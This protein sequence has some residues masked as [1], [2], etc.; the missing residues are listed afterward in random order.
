M[1]DDIMVSAVCMTYN[2]EEFIRDAIEGILNQKTDF[3]FELIIHDDAS[4]DGT[5]KIV[6]EY[7][8]KYPEII[9]PILQSTNQKQKGRNIWLSFILPEVRG[10]YIAICEGD[11]YWI[12]EDKLQIQTDFMENHQDYSMCMHNAVKLN[13]GTGEKVRMDT[14]EEAG[15]Y[16]Q[17]EHLQIGLGSDFPAFASYFLRANDWKDMPEIFW[18]GV[19]LDYSLRQ[20]YASKG[21]IYYFKEPMSVYR[22]HVPGSY[23]KRIAASQSKYN[24]YVLRMIRFYE[25]LD[26]Y[27]D[28]KFHHILMRKIVSD[29]MGFCLSIDREEGMQKAAEYGLNQERISECYNYLS[30]KYLDE[31]IRQLAEKTEQIFIYG[32][33]RVALNCSKQLRAQGVAFEGFVVSDGCLKDNELGDKKI[34]Y[35]SEVLEKYRNPGFIL[36]VQP[37]NLG[38]IEENLKKNKVESYC[39][40]YK[41]TI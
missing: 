1:K 17:E 21:K 7:A 35:L 32:T 34:F 36:G 3:R 12:N 26:N 9:R 5:A 23:M 25:R 27:L 20:Y 37:V 16:S 8:E 41:I 15:T 22:F 39:V 18:T 28:G 13:Y 6:S 30:E 10:K 38:V 40:P 2:H 24:D 4:T 14:F 31:G 29:Y 33:S 11:D 19:A